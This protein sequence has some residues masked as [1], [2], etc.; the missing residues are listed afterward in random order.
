MVFLLIRFLL[1]IFSSNYLQFNLLISATSLQNQ[2]KM[3]V[4]TEGER[5]H[6]EKEKEKMEVETEGERKHREKEKEKQ[7]KE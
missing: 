2:E 4:E 7:K 6:C 3:E 1:L 5:K